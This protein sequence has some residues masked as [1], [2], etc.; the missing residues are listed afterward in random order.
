MYITGMSTEHCTIFSVIS[1]LHDFTTDY[2]PSHRR[3][4]ST[5]NFYQRTHNTKK[6]RLIHFRTSRCSFYCPTTL[7][8]ARKTNSPTD[9]VAEK[10]LM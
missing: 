2:Y 7:A 10:P 4:P 5:Q 8:A 3:R 6:L 9:V 1:G